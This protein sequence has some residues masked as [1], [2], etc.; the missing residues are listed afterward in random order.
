MDTR[1]QRPTPRNTRTTL[2]E[3]LQ[4]AVFA[5]ATRVEIAT[6]ADDYGGTVVV[7]ADN[8]HGA[9]DL[10]PFTEPGASRWPEPPAAEIPNGHALMDCLGEQRFEIATRTAVGDA[11]RTMRHK[12]KVSDELNWTEDLATLLPAESGT[13]IRFRSRRNRAD[14]QSAARA[15]AAFMPI[16]NI[17]VDDNAVR[18]LSFTDDDK[19]SQA[20]HAGIRINVKKCRT[21][22][23]HDGRLY[24]IPINL[25]LKTIAT[26]QWEYWVACMDLTSYEWPPLQ[27]NRMRPYELAETNAVQN[28]RTKGYAAILQAIADQ[29]PAIVLPTDIVNDASALGIELATT[30]AEL[31]P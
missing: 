8:S 24:G 25:G 4:N 15:A 10:A 7:V 20:G 1:D 21:R 16:E 18:Y 5:G 26:G 28:L 14:T 2:L 27:R 22:P 17:T 6:T 31:A 12:P 19:S 30:N 3:I 23:S 13:T 11:G 9:A 29:E